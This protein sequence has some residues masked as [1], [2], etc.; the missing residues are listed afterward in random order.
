MM[1]D[2]ALPGEERVVAEVGEELGVEIDH[3]VF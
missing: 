1:D 2:L 3:A